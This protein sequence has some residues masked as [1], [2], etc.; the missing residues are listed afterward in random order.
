MPR[1]ISHDTFSLRSFE[2]ADIAAAGKG[3]IDIT[4]EVLFRVC[5]RSGH[6]QVYV[7]RAR[8]IAAANNNDLS[9]PYIKTYLLP[10]LSKDSKKETKVKKGTLDPVFK[11]TIKVLM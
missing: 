4:G 6:L 1:S 11:E 2:N 7:N 8:G 10:D 9:N 3:N 5:Y